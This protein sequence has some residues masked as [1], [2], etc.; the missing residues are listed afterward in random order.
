VKN[1]IHYINPE[2]EK[3]D[4]KDI[5]MME[6]CLQKKPISITGIKLFQTS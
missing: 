5:I 2:D 3:K 1:K 6:D 4:M